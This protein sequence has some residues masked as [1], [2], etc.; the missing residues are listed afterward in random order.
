M[1]KQ[2]Q[3]GFTIIELLTVISIIG[4]LSSI[5]MTG[6]VSARKKTRDI[7]R[8]A[9]LRQ[10]ANAVNLYYQ[11]HGYFPLGS[12]DVPG[13]GFDITDTPGSVFLPE[14]VSEGYLAKEIH[15]PSNYIGFWYLRRNSDVTNNFYLDYYCGN[16][17]PALTFFWL[18]RGVSSD[19][20]VTNFNANAE[21][22]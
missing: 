3:N 22:F 4:L 18:E 19:F 16:G 15:D 9:N 10:L 7:V 20:I 2:T 1:K 21:C 12:V 6:S 5:V 8:I 17:A 11:D 13:V 14:L